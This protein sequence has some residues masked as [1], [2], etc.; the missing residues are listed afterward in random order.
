MKT[1]LTKYCEGKGFTEDQQKDLRAQECHRI[2]EI[3]GDDGN[4]TERR[5]ACYASPDFHWRH[6]N[7]P[8]AP[9]G[10]YCSMASH[11]KPHLKRVSTMKR[12]VG[13]GKTRQ[14]GNL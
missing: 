2:L 9:I 12:R 7:N 4:V 10:Q 3:L 5:C 8:A 6:M 1:N 13:Q 11:Y 14:G